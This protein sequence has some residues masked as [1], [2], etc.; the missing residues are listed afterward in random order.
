M[1]RWT[2]GI[3]VV[4]AAILA[5]MTPA[6]DKTPTI[7]EIMTKLNKPGAIYPSL[8]KELKAAAPDWDEIHSQVKTFAKLAAE[9]GKNEPPK[10][11]KS[12]WQKLT[13]AYAD[14]AKALEKTAQKKDRSATQLAL[15]K[16]GG[17]ACGACHKSHK[18]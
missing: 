13:K 8:S 10:G 17:A 2:F 4:V 16:L 5:G 14:N 9:L 12:S 7:K 11:D 3:A 15:A 6:Q 1:S 18:K